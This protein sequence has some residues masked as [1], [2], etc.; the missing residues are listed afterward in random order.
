MAKVNG[1][2]EQMAAVLHDVVEDTHVT[3]EDLRTA[4][5]PEAVVTAVIALSKEPGEPMPDYLRRVASDP[6][7]IPV[8]RADIADNSDPIRMAALDPEMR[9]RL[10]AKYSE[11][12]R[13][14]DELTC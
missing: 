7:A 12:I 2:H 4:G 9:D 8:K 10:K 1:V 14:L 6:I 5:C 3:P 11:A 13:L